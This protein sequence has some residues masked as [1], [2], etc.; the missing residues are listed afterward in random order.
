MVGAE[1]VGATGY[2]RAKSQRLIVLSVSPALQRF[3]VDCRRRSAP[4]LSFGWGERLGGRPNARDSCRPVRDRS[5]RE[6][7]CYGARCW[8]RKGGPSRL[9]GKYLAKWEDLRRRFVQDDGC[10]VCLALPV[11]LANLPP[12]G[13]FSPFSGARYRRSGS[14]PMLKAGKV[15][16]DSYLS[17]SQAT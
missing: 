14:L 7:S 17:D 11:Y 1:G 2:K 8:F 16:A 4:F 9:V 5:L 10:F 3:R 13:G 6:E 12:E 15:L